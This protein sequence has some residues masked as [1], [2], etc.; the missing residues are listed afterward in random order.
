MSF[1]L[2][3]EVLNLTETKI[4]NSKAWLKIF[5]HK[6]DSVNPQYFDT[7]DPEYNLEKNTFSILKLISNRFRIDGKFEFL[8]EYS[9]LNGYN[10][11]KQTLNPLE[12]IEELGKSVLGYEDVSISWNQNSWGGLVRS[13]S[14]V[15]LLDGS[16]GEGSYFY[17]IGLK[18][19]WSNYGSIPTYGST[20]TDE[21][22]LWVRVFGFG[23]EDYYTCKTHA[24]NIALCMYAILIVC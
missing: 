24:N 2:P 7:R 20:N 17:A 19:V 6:L 11:W 23:V 12:E 8:L 13:T 16:V 5:R 9:N 18:D 14:T 21:V 1:Y 15:T 4:K 22:N 10:Q 3:P